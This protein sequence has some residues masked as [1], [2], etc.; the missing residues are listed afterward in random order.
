MSML[1]DIQQ[2]L[3][4]RVF[5]ASRAFHI[6]RIKLCGI[7]I[8]MGIIDIHT[9]G[10]KG[11]STT[12]S[13]SG[14]IL[15]LAE[16]QGGHGISGFIPT[17]YPADINSM[18]ENMSAIKEAME[19]QES[20]SGDSARIIGI[21][22]EGPFLNPSRHGVLDARAFVKP[23][24]YYLKRLMDGFEDIVEIISIAPEMEGAL[25]VIREISDLGII[26]SMGH[27]DASY[28]EA[29]AGYHAGARGI[30]HIFNAMRGIHHR[31]PGIAGFGIMN[32]DVYVEVIA[33]PYHLD[34]K[35][36]DLIFSVKAPDKIIIISDTVKAAQTDSG[37]KGIRNEYN[38]LL[39]GS[40]TVKEAADRLVH[41]GFREEIVLSAITENPRRYLGLDQG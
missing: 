32:K 14:E 21:H 28:T 13:S 4:Y 5:I 10:I 12:T 26:A 39:G 33:D 2:L 19:L 17:V 30:T 40:M 25:D 23:D 34:P 20:A 1:Y 27:S 29:E 6:I 37:S 41:S 7:I 8:T 31:D 15:K 3:S 22:L 16:I 11:F 38:L 35:I 24:T 9:H 36:I 18:R